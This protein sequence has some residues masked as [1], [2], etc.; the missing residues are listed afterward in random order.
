MHLQG[1]P[2]VVRGAAWR[3]VVAMQWI[4]AHGQ[5]TAAGQVVWLA[6][7]CGVGFLVSSVGVDL[8]RLPRE[9]FVLVHVVV[10]GGYLSA[11]ALRT[12]PM[13]AE[14][15][16]NWR[17]GLLLGALA[18]AFSVQYVLAQAASPADGAGG[19]FS[20]LWLGLVYGAV[21][22]LLLTVLP[23]HTV[24][25]LARTAGWLGHA[26]G[27]LATAVVAFGASLAVTVAYHLGFP[28]FRGLQVLQPAIGNGVFTL[29]YILSASPLAPVLA[30]VAMHVAA[31]L[32]GAGTSAPLPPHY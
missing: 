19:I 17:L 2:G 23:V 20:V 5:G 31:T 29:A 30:H 9:M 32:H 4:A 28:E 22:A 21:D 26:R 8:L 16:Q 24:W 6:G 27:W 7:A 3:H 14:A 10:S 25:R 11:Y 13:L 1:A 12:S 18:G 15:G